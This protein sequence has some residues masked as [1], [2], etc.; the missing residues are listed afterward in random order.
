MQRNVFNAEKKNMTKLTYHNGL[1]CSAKIGLNSKKQL[2]RIEKNYWTKTM[3]QFL[4]IIIKKF[5]LIGFASIVKETEK[6][7]SEKRLTFILVIRKN[8]LN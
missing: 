5:N 7:K 1:N 8:V 2:F 6:I 3:S 4:K